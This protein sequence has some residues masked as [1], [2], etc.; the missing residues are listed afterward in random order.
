MKAITKQFVIVEIYCNT[1]YSNLYVLF[2]FLFIAITYKFMFNFILFLFCWCC[3]L[4]LSL[5]CYYASNI[6]IYM[7]YYFHCDPVLLHHHQYHHRRL[8]RLKIIHLA[9]WFTYCKYWMRSLFFI[10]FFGY[11]GMTWIDLSWL[12]LV[13]IGQ[14]FPF[15][16]DNIKYTPSSN[17]GIVVH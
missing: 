4:F 8:C 15:T 11:C 2:L 16:D 1:I 7:L 6:V 14:T 10:H 12:V 17:Q 3:R 9:L 13:G 5:F